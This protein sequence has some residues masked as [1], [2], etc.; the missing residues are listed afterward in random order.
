[1]R[2]NGLSLILLAAALALGACGGRTVYYEQPNHGYHTPTVNPAGSQNYTGNGL[3]TRPLPRRVYSSQ[4]GAIKRDIDE[5]ADVSSYAANSKPCGNLPEIS[6]D[7]DSR[8]AVRS[9]NG[10]IG[11]DAS[12]LIN[13]RC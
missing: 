12:S 9:R 8:I 2:M 10:S 3:Q 7:V 11:Y 1:M 6:K 13:T 4:T 5:F